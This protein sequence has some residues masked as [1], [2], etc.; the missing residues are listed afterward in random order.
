MK[1]EMTYNNAEEATH[2]ALSSVLPTRGTVNQTVLSL[3]VVSPVAPFLDV[4]LSLRSAPLQYR[5]ER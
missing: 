5:I 3:I 4:D 2:N 1:V